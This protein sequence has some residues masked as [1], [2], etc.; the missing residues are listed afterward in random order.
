MRHSQRF[1]SPVRELKIVDFWV[2]FKDEPRSHS[3]DS[4]P[5]EMKTLKHDLDQYF[6]KWDLRKNIDEAKDRIVNN[7]ATKSNENA[8]VKVKTLEPTSK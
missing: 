7:E 1:S 6:T 8:L 2:E 5:K 3:Q 4:K